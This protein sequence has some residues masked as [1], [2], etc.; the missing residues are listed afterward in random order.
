MKLFG[1]KGMKIKVYHSDFCFSLH[2][3]TK[4]R[5]NTHTGGAI[6]VRVPI[7]DF[8]K[9]SSDIG[10][11]DLIMRDYIQRQ[12]YETDG[13]RYDTP[14]YKRRSKINRAVAL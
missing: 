10:Q 8:F 5:L 7:S 9:G 14:K 6:R 1:Y 2:T 13:L 4:G 11:R 12:D 3:K